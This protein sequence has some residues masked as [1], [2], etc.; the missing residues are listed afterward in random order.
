MIASMFA[1]EEDEVINCAL[2]SNENIN[3]LVS[4]FARNGCKS[5]LV[6][7]QLHNAPLKGLIF[8]IDCDFF[9]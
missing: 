2:D 7:Y 3:L 1:I 5:I 8:E 9:S 6:Q 4:L